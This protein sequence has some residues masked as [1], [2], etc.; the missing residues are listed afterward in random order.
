[1]F[2]PKSDLMRTEGKGAKFA[3]GSASE[4]LGEHEELHSSFRTHLWHCRE[5]KLT[6]LPAEGIS[7]TDYGL[8][9]WRTTWTW[10]GGEGRNVPTLCCSFPA[11][12]WHFP[13]DILPA[14]TGQAERSEGSYRLWRLRKEKGSLVF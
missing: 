10:P 3:V 6:V 8:H 5:L 13:G 1:M 7:L 4:Y 11:I 12:S 14:P 9:A 2:G